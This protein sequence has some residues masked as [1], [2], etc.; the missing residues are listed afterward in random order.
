M[1]Q[2]VALRLFLLN[3]AIGFIIRGKIKDYADE[4]YRQ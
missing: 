1:F 3:L 4:T 2:R